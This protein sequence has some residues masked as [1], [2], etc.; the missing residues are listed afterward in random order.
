MSKTIKEIKDKRKKSEHGLEYKRLPAVDIKIDAEKGIIEAY[1][2]IF[3]NV[4]LGGDKILPGAFADSLVKKLP[5]GV[6]SHNWD[7]PIAKS[8]EAREDE[9]G[10]YI[11][12]QFNLETQRGKE[13]FSD[14]KFGIIDEFSIGFRIQEYSWEMEGEE[15]VRVIKKIKLYEWSPVLA[16][17]NP[18]TELIGVK[19]DQNKPKAKFIYVNQRKRIA[20]IY[21][22]NGK[23]EELKISYRYFKY[24]KSLDEKGAKVEQTADI[25]KILR[26]RQVVKQIDKGAEF[27]LRITK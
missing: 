5:K 27:L 20:K 6:W 8:I 17:M 14:I 1:V 23:T 18:D 12:G 26:I 11:K 9:K 22:D 4:D 7:Q 24:L 3:N 13:A 15:E 2:S 19:S 10:L 16:G 25:Q 21:F